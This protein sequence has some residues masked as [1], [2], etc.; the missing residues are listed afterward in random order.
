MKETFKNSIWHDKSI[1]HNGFIAINFIIGSHL[2]P[3]MMIHPYHQLTPSPHLITF[4]VS[5][6]QLMQATCH[7]LSFCKLWENF[8]NVQSSKSFVAFHCVTQNH[9]CYLQWIRE[10]LERTISIMSFANELKNQECN[11]TRFQKIWKNSFWFCASVSSC[12][13]VGLNMCVDLMA[14]WKCY[15]ICFQI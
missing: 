1:T 13:L 9:N 7:H 14:E 15:K 8:H 6:D 3:R 5:Q 4:N 11:K 10:N 2:L 12:I